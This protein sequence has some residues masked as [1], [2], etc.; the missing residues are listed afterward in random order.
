MQVSMEYG[1]FFLVESR[2]R[3]HRLCRDVEVKLAGAVNSCKLGVGALHCEV[4]VTLVDLDDFAGGF[5][6]G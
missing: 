6:A 2:L 3:I 5:D 1:A 4:I